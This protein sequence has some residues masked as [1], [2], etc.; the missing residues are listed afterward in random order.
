MERTRVRRHMFLARFGRQ[1]VLQWADVDSREVRRYA[2]VLAGVRG[3]ASFAVPGAAA[4]AAASAA[5]AAN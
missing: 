3:P 4:E 5:S 2:D 1:S